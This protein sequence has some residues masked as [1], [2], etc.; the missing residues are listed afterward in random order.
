MSI[1]ELIQDLRYVANTT[2]AH[3]I[4]SYI[5]SWKEDN[6]TVKNLANTVGLLLDGLPR[7]K[8][9]DVVA[10]T[11]SWQHFNQHTIAALDGMTM[12]ERLVLFGLGTRFEQ[13]DEKALVYKKLH[14]QP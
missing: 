11:N 12:Q 5:E 1:D 8:G 9:D 3:S 10:L 6:T 4:V 7:N 2:D 14:A 13:E